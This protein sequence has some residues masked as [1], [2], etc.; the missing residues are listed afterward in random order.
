MADELRIGILG[1]GNIAARALIQPSQAVPGTRVVAVASRDGARAAAYAAAQG[2]GRSHG[3]YAAL[4]ADPGVDAVYVSLPNSLH[5]EWSMRALEAGKHVLCEKPLASNAR[6]AAEVAAVVART[7]RIYMEAF[8]FPYHPFAARVRDLLDTQAIGRITAA[9]ASFQIPGKFIAEQ[10]IRR[11]YALG[12]G[13]LMDAGCYALLALRRILG[14][15]ESVLEA[16]AEAAPGNPQVD[17]RMRAKL[18]FPG[19]AVGTLHASFL[20]E[21]KPDVQV[22]IEGTRGR[23][24]VDSLYVPQWGGGLRLEW[25]GRSYAEP[26]GQVQ[27][28]EYQLREFLRCVREGA[29]V[30]TSVEAGAANMRAI[31]AI[32]QK[33]GLALR[34]A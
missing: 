16:S 10:N 1:T 7:G 22:V 12:G 9:S 34:G 29:P 17:L 2:I 23:L 31:D 13:A 30:L 24:V 21:E 32:Y 28:Y 5:A 8:H 25:D 33:A 27:R 18:A 6:E 15:P 14:E 19:G 20:A 11:D 26:A 3:D 4:L